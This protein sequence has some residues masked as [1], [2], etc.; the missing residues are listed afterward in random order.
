MR[1]HPEGDV[2]IPLSE[3][4]GR[5]MVIVCISDDQSMDVFHQFGVNRL[6]IMYVIIT[7]FLFH[8][9]DIF[10]YLFESQ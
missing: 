5:T 9:V 3:A 7:F 6:I 8:F 4:S 10:F 2:L 1:R